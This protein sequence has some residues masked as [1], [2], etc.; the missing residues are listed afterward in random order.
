[1]VWRQLKS[2][3]LHLPRLTLP[4]QVI[5]G[6]FAVALGVPLAIGLAVAGWS[7]WL[8]ALPFLASLPIMVLMVMAS[9][10]WRREVP[11]SCTTVGEAARKLALHAAIVGPLPPQEVAD[12]LKQLIHDQLD[13]PLD[14]IK[15][16]SRLLDWE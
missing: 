14:D 5:G 10:P 13:V 9:E 4:N 2:D 1:M 11:A 15:P 6:V 7:L 16:E 3:G 8:L 12:E